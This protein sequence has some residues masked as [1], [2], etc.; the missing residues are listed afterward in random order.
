MQKQESICSIERMDR[1]EQIPP[2][3]EAGMTRHQIAE[4][5]GITPGTV[6][7]WLKKL[8][9][10]TVRPTRE[11][12]PPIEDLTG[13]RFGKQ[14]VVRMTYADRWEWRAVCKCD[15]GSEERVVAR[16]ALI[17]GMSTSCGCRR[18]H[19]QKIS[20]ANHCFFSGHEELPG[21]YWGKIIRRAK[22]YGKLRLT[23]VE[24]RDL[25]INQ[26][27][28]CALTGLP[29]TFGRA[30]YSNETTASLDRIDSSKGYERGNVQWVHKVVNIM[31]GTLTPAEFLQ[32][33]RLIVEHADD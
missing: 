26:D 30:E 32:F 21:R 16:A 8:E 6:G 14:V 31:K 28:K 29:I 7:Y 12:R 9:L 19:Y 10:K 5:L 2:L 20:G 1:S 15:C 3:V 17:R 18:D 33:C 23:I 22:R 13:R 24:A 27:Q 11:V 4:E 25:F